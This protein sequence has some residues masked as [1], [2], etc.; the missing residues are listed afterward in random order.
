MSGINKVIVLGRLGQ[1]PDVR[2][3]ASGDAITNISVATSEE[4][5]N[6][7]TGEKESK[8]EWHKITFFGGLAK[9]AGDYLKKGSQVYVEGK[10]QTRQWE[11]SDG[12]TRYSTEIIVDGFGG[13]MEML[14]GGEG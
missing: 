4:W 5:K 6:K 8:T 12:N 3:N 1:D 2:Y 7:T 10:I 11:D 9:V 14:G 13:K